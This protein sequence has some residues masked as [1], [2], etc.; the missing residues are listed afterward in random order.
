VAIDYYLR[1]PAVVR[2][3]VLLNGTFKCDG[4]PE[5]LN[6]PYEH[7]VE[8]LL[9]MVA[10]KP[11]MAAMV[12]T[13]FQ[14]PVETDEPALREGSDGEEA[15]VRVLSSMNSHLKSHVLAPFTTEQTTV[16]YAHQLIDF[17]SRDVRPQA[18]EVKVPVLLIAAE[19]DQVATPAG[20]KA[21]ADLFPNA[22]YLFLRGST[23]YCLYDR[24]EFLGGVLKDFFSNPAAFLVSRWSPDTVWSGEARVAQPSALNADGAISAVATLSP[25]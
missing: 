25:N 17:W 3:M 23:H 14:N 4:S 9:R 16:N 12:R 11:A 20:A 21:A 15:S 19:Y 18:R 1:R 7:N 6:S 13:T 2:S 8:S 22:H 10:K 24:P 5:H